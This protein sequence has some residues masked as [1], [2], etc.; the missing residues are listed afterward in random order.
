MGV[1]LLTHKKQ[2]F[3]LLYIHGITI[4]ANQGDFKKYKI[5]L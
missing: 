1:T 3:F 4:H 2:Y 5:V